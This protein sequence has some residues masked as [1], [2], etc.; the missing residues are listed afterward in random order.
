MNLSLRHLFG[1]RGGRATRPAHTTQ[2]RV[3]QL[4]ERA[5]PTVNL[6]PYKFAMP[7]VGTFHATNENFATGAFQGVFTDA[8][9]GI[10]VAVTG[11]LTP[12]GGHWKWDTM[13]FQGN[14][15]RWF[16]SEHVKFNG[17]L[18]EGQQL[19]II[20]PPMME[21]YLTESLTWFITIPP[22]SSTTTHWEVSVG[23]WI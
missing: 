1:K 21:G 13:T 15:W 17:Y 7:G 16:E 20:I 22:H 8:K 19:D 23:Q 6:L 9:T 2:L 10:N 5:V 12:L 18:N 3:E 4:E 11:K 14:G